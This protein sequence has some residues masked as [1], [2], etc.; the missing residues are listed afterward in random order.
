MKVTLL[1]LLLLPLAGCAH[2]GG[3]YA[4][5][6][7][8]YFYDGECLYPDGCYRP[9]YFYYSEGTQT[10]RV[11]ERAR[12][13]T[14]EHARTT[15]VITRQAVSRPAAAGSISARSAPRASSPRSAPASAARAG[16]RR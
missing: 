16:G 9:G 3:G 14:V 12:V 13:M 7:A 10:P 11:I 1:V 5:G 6:G 2:Q 8:G 15:R 4:G